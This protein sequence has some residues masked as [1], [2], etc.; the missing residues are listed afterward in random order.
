MALAW[1]DMGR[2]G[3]ASVRWD[4]RAGKSGT[5]AAVDSIEIARGAICFSY[6]GGADIPGAA[7]VRQGIFSMIARE[8]PSLR[9]LRAFG[10]RGEERLV[11]A[12][13]WKCGV[14]RAIRR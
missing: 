2:G 8:I 10:N 3:L 14:A 4:V 7:G 12:S 11:C 9:Q 13:S 5:A 1:T 6:K